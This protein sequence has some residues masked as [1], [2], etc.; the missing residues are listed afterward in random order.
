MTTMNTHKTNEAIAKIIGEDDL[1]FIVK[2]GLF[3]RPNAA[4]YTSSMLEAWR[5]PLSEAKPHERMVNEDPITI[6]K[7]PPRDFCGSHDAMAIA[8]KWIDRES[9][10]GNYVNELCKIVRRDH[11]PKTGPMTAMIQAFFAT[12][13]QEAEAF[14]NVFCTA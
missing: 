5:L 12:P 11:D 6:M 2:R 3:Y 7:C 13:K 4:G 1:H 14:L 10:R 9:L 8:K